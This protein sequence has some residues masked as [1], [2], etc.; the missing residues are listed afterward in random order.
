MT[1]ILNP[2]VNSYKRLIPGYEAPVYITWGHTNRSSLIRI[3]K[4]FKGKAKSTRAELRNPDPSCNI[5]LAFA[6]MLEAGL[7][8][9]KKDLMPP[10]PVE[11]DVYNFDETKLENENIKTLPSSLLSA[12]E[13]LKVDKLIQ[14]TLGKHTYNRYLAVKLEEWEQFRLEVTNW[15]LERYIERY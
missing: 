8:G 7:D 12:L 14:K 1:S 5:Y 9:I 11:G 2:L 4:H 3:P 15:E 13:K 10:P 6:V